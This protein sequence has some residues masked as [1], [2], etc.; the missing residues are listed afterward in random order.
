[1][2]KLHSSDE[3]QTVP[4][5]GKGARGR[6]VCEGGEQRSDS[7]EYSRGRCCLVLFVGVSVGPKHSTSFL[8]FVFYR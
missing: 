1:M 3:K 2:N 5:G 4:G 7:V 8:V 6:A